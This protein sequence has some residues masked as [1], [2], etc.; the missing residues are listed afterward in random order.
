MILEKS[1]LV[2]CLALSTVLSSACGGGGSGSGGGSSPT[3]PSSPTGS[4]TGSWTGTWTSAR[5]AGGSMTASLTQSG[6]S[7]T[8]AVSSTGSPCLTTGNVSGTVSGGS[9]TIGA[10]FGV[11]QQV[12]FTG[13]V[14][15]AWSNVN[16]QYSV[17]GGL[18]AGDA[19]TWTISKQ[20][21]VPS[22]IL[23]NVS[24]TWSLT[25]TGNQPH[26]QTYSTFTV[27][28][29]QSGANI[30]GN[31]LPIGTSSSTP[32]S[33]VSSV[34]IAGEVFFGSESAYWNG[35]NDGYFRLTLDSTSNRM[36]GGCNSSATCTSATATRIR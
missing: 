5:G 9:V 33:S 6:T 16:G 25:R 21:G 11:S 15:T 18:C 12:N 28:M 13:S 3:T 7:L 26:N 27:T 22:P 2:R 1:A 32:I 19:G 31:I 4:L 20:S 34:S 36:T 10:V 17:S 35:G 23:P 29:V 24:G 8:G 30:S 14:N